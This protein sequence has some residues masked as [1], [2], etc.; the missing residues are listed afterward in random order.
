[1][2]SELLDRYL[3]GETIS[4]EQLVK[5]LLAEPSS[6]PAAAPFYRA[7]TAVG[8]R[9]AQE[10]FIALRLAMAGEVPADAAVREVRALLARAQAASDEAERE[11]A[12]AEYRA[13]LH[14]TM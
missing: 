6:Q 4:K 10:A 13:R 14:A 3:L 11:I 1:V 2:V 5:R 8:T 9:A 7:L 12:R